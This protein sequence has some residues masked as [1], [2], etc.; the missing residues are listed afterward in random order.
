MTCV[1][2][3]PSLPLPKLVIP[4]PMPALPALPSLPKLPALPACPC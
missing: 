1:C 2:K 3:I 4:L